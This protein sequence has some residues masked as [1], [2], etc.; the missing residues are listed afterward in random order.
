VVD[1]DAD[2]RELLTAMLQGAGAEVRA[3]G[4]V[5][6]ALVVMPVLQPDAIVSDIGIPTEDGYALAKRLREL[7]PDHGGQ[8]PAIALTAFA[9]PRDRK[10]AFD[11]GFDG[12]LAKPV[13][14]PDLVT[15][16]GQL[17]SQS[18]PG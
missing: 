1:D 9:A 3:V 13:S 17:V 5:R 8:T 14:A 10:L 16:V 7:P 15:L 4:S 12:F 18:A 6:D 2:A 11:A